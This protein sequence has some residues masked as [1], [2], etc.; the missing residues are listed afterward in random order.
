MEIKIIR[1]FYKKINNE[2]L[3][4]VKKIL[5]IVYISS[6]NV[7]HTLKYLTNKHRPLHVFFLFLIYILLMICKK[8]KNTHFR[9][10]IKTNILEALGLF[11][12]IADESGRRNTIKLTY[13]IYVYISY[14]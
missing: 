3:S 2:I 11:L 13:I 4:D 12:L 5:N 10:R 6:A 9:Q 14:M 7:I 8:G 1:L